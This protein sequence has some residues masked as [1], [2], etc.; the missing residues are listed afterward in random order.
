MKN[1]IIFLLFLLSSCSIFPKE[2][3]TIYVSNLSPNIIKNISIEFP[4][5]TLN[6]P[7]LNPGLTRGGSFI[8]NDPEDFFGAIKVGWNN[9]YS[10]NIIRNFNLKKNDLPSFLIHK[11]LLIFKFISKITK[12]K[13]SLMTPRIKA[14]KPLKW[15]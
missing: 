9:L 10:E 3:P 13:L 15:I 6:L 8:V 7:Q 14:I 11:I 4:K 2:A 5:K 12:F 1:L